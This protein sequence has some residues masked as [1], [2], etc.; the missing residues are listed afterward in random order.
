MMETLKTW[1]VEILFSLLGLSLFVGKLQMSAR[2]RNTLTLILFAVAAIVLH[3]YDQK[4][5]P[6]WP[7]DI[8]LNS[9]LAL[10]A[11]LSKASFMIA[12]AET[13]SQWKWNM[14]ENSRPLGDFEIIDSASRG[15][16]GSLR[17]VSR[18]KWQ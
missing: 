6:N 15:F 16:W 10:F 12:L 11:T 13:I 2:G 8:T 3:L 1:C 14:F 4:G 7:F 9:F 5:P 18:F 17:V